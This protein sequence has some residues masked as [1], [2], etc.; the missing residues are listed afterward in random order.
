[1][2]LLVGREKYF[3]LRIYVQILFDQNKFEPVMWLVQNILNNWSQLP[4]LG[5]KGINIRSVGLSSNKQL[6]ISKNKSKMYQFG[7]K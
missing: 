7:E 3:E 6:T 2:G 1:M 4:A 5:L